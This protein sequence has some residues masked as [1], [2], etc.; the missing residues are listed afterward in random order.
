MKRNMAFSHYC[1]AGLLLLGLSSCAKLPSGSSGQQSGGAKAVALPVGL[2]RLPQPQVAPPVNRDNPA[3]V[4]VELETKVVTALMADGVGYTYW[5]YNGT[6]PGP[7]IR[8][9]QGDTVELTLK[10]SLDSPVSHSIDSHGVTGPGGGGKLTQTLPGGTSVFRFKA[11]NP[12]VYIYHCATPM[13]PHHISHGL[14][15]L[16][17]VEPPK[18]WPKVDR[19]FYIMQGDFYLSG[20]PT[21]PGMHE[22]VVDKMLKEEPDYVVFNGSV[23]ALSEENAL[24]ANVGETVRVFFGVGGPNTTSSVHLIGE[25]FDRVYPEGAS[26]PLSNV[27][28]H[29]VPAGAAAIF[30]VKLDVPGTYILVDHSLARLHKGAAAFLTV[31]GPENPAVFQSVVN[32]SPSISGGH[33]SYSHCVGMPGLRSG[34]FSGENDEYHVIDAVCRL[35]TTGTDPTTIWQRWFSNSLL[36]AISKVSVASAAN[37]AG[38]NS[39]KDQSR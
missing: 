14:Y 13:I 21:Q 30:E 12:G 23:G 4:S 11:L 32:T 36:R 6:V 18:G 9:R 17:V 31:E 10:N 15:G 20:D 22:A 16:M 5:T 29:L 8:V 27:Q 28:S 3:I 39:G 26:E 33:S 19:E 7:M 24:R 35:C 38:A 2:M 37:N 25:I 34:R 1:L